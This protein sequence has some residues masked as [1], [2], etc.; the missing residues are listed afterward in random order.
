M[1][2]YWKSI[3]LFLITNFLRNAV[4]ISNP[5]G[6]KTGRCGVSP[7]EGVADKQQSGENRHC[8]QGRFVERLAWE[9]GEGFPL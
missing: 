7:L 1:V 2:T 4:G 3:E 9:R 6:N 5:C 8:L